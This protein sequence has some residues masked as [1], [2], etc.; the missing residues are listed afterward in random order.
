MA[1]GKPNTTGFKG[2]YKLSPS[3][4]RRN[5]RFPDHEYYSRVKHIGQDITC[6]TALTIREAAIKRD[7]KIL[8]LKINE[9]LQIL[10]PYGKS[11]DSGRCTEA[12]Q[13]TA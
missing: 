10:K 6:G 8:E 7:I 13:Q 9:P 4:R 12:S 1:K 11:N 3:S 2:V 5:P